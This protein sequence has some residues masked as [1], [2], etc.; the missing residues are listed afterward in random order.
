[1][2]ATRTLSGSL[3]NVAAGL[4]D[5]SAICLGSGTLSYDII[6]DGAAQLRLSSGK[7]IRLIAGRNQGS[8]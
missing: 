2:A 1:V 8:I 4:I 6:S 3:R 7:V 5:A